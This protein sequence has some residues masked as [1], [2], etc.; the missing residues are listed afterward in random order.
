MR[1]FFGERSI[2]CADGSWAKLRY[3]RL[4]EEMEGRVGYGAE[5]VMQRGQVCERAQVADF[6]TIPAR[7]D[8]FLTRICRCAVTPCTLRDVAQDELELYRGEEP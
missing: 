8:T 1:D 2:L 6:T 3:Y 5:V 7:I 4:A